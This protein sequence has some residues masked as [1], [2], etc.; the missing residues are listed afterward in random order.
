MYVRYVELCIFFN[1]MEGV[2]GANQGFGEG[3][4]DIYV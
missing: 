1:G 4:I 2:V 3:E